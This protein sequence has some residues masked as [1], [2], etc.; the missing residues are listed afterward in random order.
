MNEYLNKIVEEV[1]IDD[2]TQNGLFYVEINEHKRMT[3]KSYK[4]HSYPKPKG[5]NGVRLNYDYDF[6]TRPQLENQINRWEVKLDKLDT[7]KSMAFITLT[8]SSLKTT[9][10]QLGKKLEGFITNIKRN[11][12]KYS[13]YVRRYEV[14]GKLYKHIHLIVFFDTKNAPRDLT[15]KWIRKHWKLGK[16]CNVKKTNLYGEIKGYICKITKND[17]NKKDNNLTNYPPLLR[18][19]SS[20]QKLEKTLDRIVFLTNINGI[21]QLKKELNSMKLIETDEPLKT[22]V[23]KHITKTNTEYQKECIDKIYYY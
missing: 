22:F 4:P 5:F 3:T 13:E 16:S 21:N 20:S 15:N 19:I 12:N 2:I 18:V 9:Y 11:F 1:R 10:Q 8:T 17:I 7:N 6:M 14:N 23:K